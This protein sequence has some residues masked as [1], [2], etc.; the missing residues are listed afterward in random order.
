MCE[1][2]GRAIV[3]VAIFA[4]A[5]VWESNSHHTSFIRNAIHCSLIYGNKYLLVKREIFVLVQHNLVLQ[6]G[7]NNSAKYLNAKA[8]TI[9][10]D[11]TTPK[12]VGTRNQTRA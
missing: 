6:C 3:Y 9:Q 7:I 11:Q 1:L 5:M 8:K 2:H 10:F 12:N 4:N